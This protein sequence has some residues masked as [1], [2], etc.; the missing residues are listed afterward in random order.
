MARRPF[1]LTPQQELQLREARPQLKPR[2]IKCNRQFGIECTR[3]T[4]RC[5][6]YRKA[7]VMFGE[8]FSV[9]N[10]CTR[11][12]RDRCKE[13]ANKTPRS[14]AGGWQQP[15]I[16]NPRKACQTKPKS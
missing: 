15:F 5:N 16:I 13:Q 7:T 9:Y 14:K 3:H 6:A 10:H 12:H 2:C 1:T 8:T 4:P 11:C